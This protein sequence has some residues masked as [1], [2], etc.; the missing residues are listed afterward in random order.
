MH[1]EEGATIQDLL[2]ELEITRKVAISVN[3][4]QETGHSRQLNDGD[5]VMICSTVGGE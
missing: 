1:L 3:D 2:K 5:K 4:V